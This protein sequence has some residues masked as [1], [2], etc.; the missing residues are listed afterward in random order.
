MPIT[1]ATLL[2]GT[3]CDKK[4]T[5]PIE[6]RCNSYVLKQNSPMQMT[7][8]DNTHTFALDSIAENQY[9]HKIAHMNI[10]GDERIASYKNKFFWGNKDFWYFN[11][12]NAEY[13]LTIDSLIDSGKDSLLFT[14]CKE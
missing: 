10:N 4:P 5:E 3:S 1:A 8:G 7:L 13:S 6:P 11:P 12:E 2:A 14:I 9:G